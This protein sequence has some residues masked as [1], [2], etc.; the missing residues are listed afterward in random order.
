[1]TA[2]QFAIVLIG[3][4]FLCA[5]A[6]KVASA[7]FMLDRFVAWGHEGPLMFVVGAIELACAVMILAPRTQILGTVLLS[8]VM[9]GAIVTHVRAAEPY[10]LAVPLLVLA[11]TTSWLVRLTNPP[12]PL[13][14]RQRRVR[15]AGALS[16]K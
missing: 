16:T 9:L 13:R 6:A 8:V 15:P 2:A 1:M 10:L 3:L 5:G 4:T 11:A 12:R 14:A 7:E